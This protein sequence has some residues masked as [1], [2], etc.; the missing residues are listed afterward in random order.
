LLTRLPDGSPSRGRHS[1]PV[2]SA[3]GSVVAFLSKTAEMVGEACDC[4][5]DLYLYQ[6]R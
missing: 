1:G 6:V 4:S 5:W 2:I 3:D